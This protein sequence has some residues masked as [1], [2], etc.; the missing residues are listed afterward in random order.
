VPTR[1]RYQQIVDQ[2]EEAVRANLATMERV[3]DIGEII[4][5]SQR[6]LLRAV[7]V[8]HGTTPSRFAQSLR[9][10]E[11]RK[12]LLSALAGTETDHGSG[13][14][15]RLPRA[16]PFRSRLSSGVRRKPLGDH[17][18]Q[19]PCRVSLP[20]QMPQRPLIFHLLIRPL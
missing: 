4:T 7:R 3:A 1:Q 19:L 16:R 13:D 9:L 20:K 6:T 18:P 12:E 14:A 8:I 11:A 10:A 15:L 5:V 2:F 17:A